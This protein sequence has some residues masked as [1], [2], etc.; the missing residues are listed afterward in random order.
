M[1]GT[2]LLTWAVLLA[3]CWFGWQFLRQN[4][5]MLLRLEELEK[6]LDTLEV[7]E[8]DQPEANGND[9]VERFSNR[10]LAHSKIERDGLKAGTVAPDLRLPRLD[11]RGELAL[12]DLR[13][14]RV[15]L[16]FSSPECGPCSALAPQ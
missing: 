5:R 9:R 2:L 13:G 4:G 10:S 14:R 16:V 1:I 3:V 15:L 8:D 7:G 6:R 12:S 11:G